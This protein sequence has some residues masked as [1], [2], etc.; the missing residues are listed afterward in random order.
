MNY[1]ACQSS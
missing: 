1:R